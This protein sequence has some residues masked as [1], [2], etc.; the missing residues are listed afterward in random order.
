MI[1]PPHRRDRMQRPSRDAAALIVLCLPL[2]WAFDATTSLKGITL[3]VAE[4][5]ELRRVAQLQLDTFSPPPEQ[6]A[7]LPMLQ[8]FFEANQKNV[9]AGM[10]KRL[11]DE[12][13]NRVAKGSEILIAVDETADAIEEGLVD[14]FGQ[15][16]EPG[17][18]CAWSPPS[19]AHRLL[20]TVDLSSQEM[21][22]PTH[23]VAGG[24]Y[25]SHMAVAEAS[26]RRGVGRA[27]LGAASK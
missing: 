2:A 12:L 27:L 15:Y 18:P 6:P 11:S 20:G 21:N 14:A 16:V 17:Q 3:R 7:L 25:L 4:P 26:R 1:R 19:F 10:L 22:L 8:T 5:H 24:L 23:A 9:R 13:A